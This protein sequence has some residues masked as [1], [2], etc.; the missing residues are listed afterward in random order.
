MHTHWRG[1]ALRG[2]AIL[3]RSRSSTVVYTL[4]LYP[5]SFQSQ[6]GG[7]GG[8]R[9]GGTLWALGKTNL[10]TQ[11]TNKNFTCIVVLNFPFEKIVPEIRH[12]HLDAREKAFTHHNFGGK[13]FLSIFCLLT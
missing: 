1:N 4:F 5:P 2:R 12:D 11:E 7:R 13:L 3:S 10:Y 8:G 9:G 6:W